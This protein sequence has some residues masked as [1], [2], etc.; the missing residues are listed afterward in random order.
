MKIKICPICVTVSALWFLI[1]IGIW[2]R[3]LTDQNWRLLTAL[4]M[5]GSV[6]GIA[7]QRN[8]FLWKVASIALG[9]PI[10]FLLIYDI[11]LK[12]IVI[13]AALLLVLAYFLF[14]KRSFSESN[15]DERVSKLEEQMKNCC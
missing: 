13:E 1:T 14:V 2:L 5:G 10:A 7:Y 3:V 9:M 15:N 12:T 11:S 6:V 8:S 4:L